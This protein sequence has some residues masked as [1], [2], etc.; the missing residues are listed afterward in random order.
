MQTSESEQRTP[1]T[2][3]GSALECSR[4]VLASMENPEHSVEVTVLLNRMAGGDDLAAGHLIEVLQD[5]LRTIA[6]RHMDRQ[7]AGHTLQTTALLN[8]AWIK[9]IGQAEVQWDSRRHFVR[10]ATTVMRSVLVD[11]ARSR[12]SQKRGGGRARC[13]LDEGMAVSDEG[14]ESLLALHEALERLELRDPEVARVAELRCFGGRGHE[15]IADVLDIS[16]ATVTRRWK[17]AKAWL[18]KALEEEE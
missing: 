1:P 7:G 12:L 4:R 18:R 2:P 15:E 9:L 11:H 3:R 5:E 17:T 10:M 16:V 8:E 13:E 6:H 14:H